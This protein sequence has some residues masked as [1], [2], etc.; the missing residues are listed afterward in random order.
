MSSMG[1]YHS[2]KRSS[3]DK[4][5]RMTMDIL[6]FGPGLKGIEPPYSWTSFSQALCGVNIINMRFA[7]RIADCTERAFGLMYEI[8]YD[9]R[10]GS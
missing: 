8:N 1:K 4:S 7:V 10:E 3:V 9:A 2:E 5:L 6:A